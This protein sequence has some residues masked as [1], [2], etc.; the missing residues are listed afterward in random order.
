MGR[1]NGAGRMVLISGANGGAGRAITRAFLEAG[2]TVA[3]VARKIAAADFDHPNFVAIPADLLARDGAAK[4]VEIAAG[5][6][7]RIDVLVHVMGGFTMGQSV[8]ETGDAD[9]ERMLDINFRSAL[10]AIRAVM[11]HMLGA[12]WGRVIAIGSRQAVEP[13]PRIGAYSVSKAALVTLV[14][15]LALEVK[16]TGITANAI[17]P[18]VIDTPANRAAMP[19]ADPKEWVRPEAIASLAV[20]LASDLAGDV[21]G[22]A[23]P[24][25]GPA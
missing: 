17:L 9:W 13:G 12:G 22:V 4:A 15:T 6:A 11:P 10:W 7:K 3:G 8:W 24:I 18:G 5:I 23:V 14:R 19:S 2:D 21:N 20:W 1:P 25:Y 16:G